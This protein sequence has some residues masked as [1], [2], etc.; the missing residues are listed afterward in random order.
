M[1]LD[2]F[3]LAVEARTTFSMVCL[4]VAGSSITCRTS[5][6]AREVKPLKLE[7]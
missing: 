3:E 6:V 7:A 1:E 5:R 2:E 4:R